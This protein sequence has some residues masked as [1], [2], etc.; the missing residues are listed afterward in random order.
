MK[1]PPLFV[2]LF[3]CSGIQS[4]KIRID[5]D[6]DE[7]QCIFV[8]DKGESGQGMR[9]EGRNVIHFEHCKTNTLKRRRWDDFTLTA[10]DKN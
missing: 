7:I 3:N 10:Y 1:L 5:N 9:G 4:G 2:L 6:D 8:D